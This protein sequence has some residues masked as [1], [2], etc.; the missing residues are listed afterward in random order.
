MKIRVIRSSGGG[1]GKIIWGI[2]LTVMFGLA[3]VGCLEDWQE[4]LIPMIVCGGL[5]VAG[6]VL[7]VQGIQSKRY[8]QGPTNIPE[9][10]DPDLPDHVNDRIRELMQS[11]GVTGGTV[12][13]TVKRVTY[14]SSD[15]TSR[16]TETVTENRSGM[17]FQKMDTHEGTVTCEA[18]GG[19]AKLRRGQSGVCE[20]CGSHIQG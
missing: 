16:T 15:G 4:M 8:A 1:T 6:I 5:T 2:I 18:C 13:K 12:S 19:V 9:E 14:T 20:Y 3:T 17:P 10:F 7:I 11:S